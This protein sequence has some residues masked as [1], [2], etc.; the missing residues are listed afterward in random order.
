MIYYCD[1]Q[2]RP[3]QPLAPPDVNVFPDQP[4]VIILRHHPQRPSQQR[5]ASQWD[6]RVNCAPA[7][8]PSIIRHRLSPRPPFESSHPARSIQLPVYRA[9]GEIFT[10]TTTT[11]QHHHP[12]VLAVHWQ[13]FTRVYRAAELDTQ[14][15]GGLVVDGNGRT[16][17]FFCPQPCSAK[18]AEQ[19]EH[20]TTTSS[21]AGNGV[22]IEQ[23]SQRRACSSRQA[24]TD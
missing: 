16:I 24:E 3:N 20:H 11:P 4:D 7:I 17:D 14:P 13:C 22:R 8:P 5:R 6:S 9:R 23:S 2:L 18:S 19:P 15:V 12:A 10:T 1:D 21:P